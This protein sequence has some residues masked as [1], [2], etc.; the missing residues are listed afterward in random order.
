MNDV[1]HFPTFSISSND[2]DDN[3]SR[4]RDRDAMIVLQRRASKRGK[5]DEG[6]GWLIWIKGNS[7]LSKQDERRPIALI[8][9]RQF[10]VIPLKDYKDIERKEQGRVGSWPTY[11]SSQDSNVRIQKAKITAQHTQW[12][13]P[14]CSTCWSPEAKWSRG[15]VQRRWNDDGFDNKGWSP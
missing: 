11:I 6:T 7:L 12:W 8:Q 9:T 14:L 4:D 2:N 1:H 5:R 13:R 15:N 10:L 3:N